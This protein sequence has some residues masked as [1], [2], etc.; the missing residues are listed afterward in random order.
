MV[1]GVE[2]MKEGGREEVYQVMNMLLLC[3]T[4]P[5]HFQPF[6]GL[7]K[8]NFESRNTSLFILKTRKGTP[9]CHE[10]P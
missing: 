5:P 9:G 1:E 2:D 8:C 6:L 4:P 7:R 3:H 10:P